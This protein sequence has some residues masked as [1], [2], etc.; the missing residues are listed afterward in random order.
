M[1][2]TKSPRSISEVG[3][4]EDF[5]LQIARGQIV[6]HSLVNKFGTNNNIGSTMVPI[7]LGGVY[8]TPQVGGATA[9]R[10]KAGGNANDTAAGT[11]AR[12]VT[13]QGLDETG[14]LVTETLATAGISASALTTTTFLRLFR[15]W[16]S[17][18]G[19]YA[20][21]AAGSHA[22]AI[23]IENG[24]GGTDWA[25]IGS[26][27]FPQGQS[28]IACYSV[29]LGYTAYFT[30]CHYSVESGKSPDILM[31]KRENILET[32]APYSA[33][34]V[35]FFLEGTAGAGTVRYNEAPIVFPELTDIGFMATVATS[36]AKIDIEFNLILVKNTG[37]A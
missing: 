25:T 35:V 6:G 4:T 1:A 12:E 14:A 26:F 17:A 11:G 29:P 15:A 33:M 27:G 9:L 3:T 28:Q 20:T 7:T 23:T 37:T 2:L 32:A 31:F 8:R 10:I 36:T 34:R 30:D 13:L 18:S 19:T 16:V 21:A 22:A 24:T 5:R